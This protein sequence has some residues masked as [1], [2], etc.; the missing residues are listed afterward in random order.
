MAQAGSR[1]TSDNV[2]RVGSSTPEHISGVSAADMVMGLLTLYS[3]LL[4]VKDFT[5]LLLC[6]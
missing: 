2:M 3:L 5:P 4:H 1:Q 6:L